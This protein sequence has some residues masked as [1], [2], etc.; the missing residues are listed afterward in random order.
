MLQSFRAGKTFCY[1]LFELVLSF[2]QILPSVPVQFKIRTK[3]KTSFWLVPFVPLV[4][5]NRF[6]TRFFQNK[7]VVLN[8]PL[9]MSLRLG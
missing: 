8:Q 3:R 7:A 9:S 4:F 5:R 2:C 1:N 6:T